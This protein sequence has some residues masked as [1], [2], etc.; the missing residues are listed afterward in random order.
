MPH[1][2]TAREKTEQEED[3]SMLCMRQR[4]KTDQE[5]AESHSVGDSEGKDRTG[6]N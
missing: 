5:E 2:R 6:R 3:E 1:C 4:E